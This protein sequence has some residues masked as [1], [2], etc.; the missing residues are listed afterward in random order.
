MEKENELFLSI[1]EGKIF[2]FQK[3]IN[4]GFPIDKM[5]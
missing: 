4:G 2:N 1:Y 3:I 5:V